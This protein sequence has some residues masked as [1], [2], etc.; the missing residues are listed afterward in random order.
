MTTG[1]GFTV[2]SAG[3]SDGPGIFHLYR[4]A[5]RIPGG[6]AREEDEITMEYVSSNLD[7]ALRRGVC[8]VAEKTEDVGRLSGEIHC[9]APEP[10]VFRHILSDLTVVVH[11][12]VRGRGLGRLIF[13]RLLEHIER[14]MPGVL[15]VEFVARESNI[16]AVELYRKLGFVQEG[17]FEKRINGVSGS[18]EADIPMAWFNKGY[19][20]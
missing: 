9:I 14:N 2:R 18:L 4:E 5:A 19:R 13:S 15:R 17:R 12:E 20:G 6:I 8:L 7:K 11:P 16:R 1:T 10:R 3:M